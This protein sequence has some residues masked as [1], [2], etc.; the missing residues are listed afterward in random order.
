[1]H[2]LGEVGLTTREACG[3]AVRNVTGSPLAGICPH[4]PFD[5][6]PYAAACARYFLRHT[7]TQHLPRKFESSF[8]CCDQDDAISDIQD[9]GFIPGYAR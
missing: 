2:L 8:S 5:V 9:L 6:T 4:E 1:M 7:L 3:N